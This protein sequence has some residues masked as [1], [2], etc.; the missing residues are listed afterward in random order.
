[1]SHSL[2]KSLLSALLGGAAAFIFAPVLWPIV[3]YLE[4]G[5]LS[6]TLLAGLLAVAFFALLGGLA[7]GLVIG[8]PLLALLKKVRLHSPLL[9]VSIG[10]LASAI[11][12]SQFFSWPLS[13]WPLYGYFLIIGG[14]CSAVAA[15]KNAL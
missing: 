12:F 4:Q 5:D 7:F 10:S 2:T 3:V 13:A 9:I 11:V 15:W 14:L 8:F 1:M 6:S